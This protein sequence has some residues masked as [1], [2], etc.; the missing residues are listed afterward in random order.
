MRQHLAILFIACLCITPFYLM[1]RRPWKKKG[2]T[3]RTRELFLGLFCIFMFG[4]LF[5]TFRALYPPLGE[6]WSNAV[7]RMRNHSDVYFTP[8][9]NIRYMYYNDDHEH[10]IMNMLGNTLMFIPWGFGRPLLWKKQKKFVH[11]LFG[12]LLLTLFIESVQLFSYNRTVDIDDI[13]LN[14]L[15]SLTGWVL[16]VVVARIFPKIKKYAV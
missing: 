13:I 4:L 12:A 6:M 10:F 16:Y 8:F 5:M 9:E 14:A 3:A 11:A 1:L 15:G 2:R 7:D